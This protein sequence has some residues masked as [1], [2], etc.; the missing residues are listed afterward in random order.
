LTSLTLTLEELKHRSLEEILQ[1]VLANQHALTVRLPD[2]A[3]VIIQPKLQLKPLP[4]LEGYV[5]QGWK[6]AIYIENSRKE[7]RYYRWRQG[8]QSL[9]RRWESLM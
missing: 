4:I 8:W 2:G 6:E 7:G 9:R 5:P 1:S 3:E